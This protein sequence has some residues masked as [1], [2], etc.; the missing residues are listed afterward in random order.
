MVFEGG[1]VSSEFSDGIFFA[2]D[3][4]VEEEYVLFQGGFDGL[5]VVMV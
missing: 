5:H 1:L 2:L 4:L 3:Y